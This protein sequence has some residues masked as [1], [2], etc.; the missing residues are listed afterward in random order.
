[1]FNYTACPRAL[2]P[3]LVARSLTIAVASLIELAMVEQGL[4]KNKRCEAWCGE[5]DRG[6]LAPSCK[7]AD[8]SRVRAEESDTIKTMIKNRA[9]EGSETLK[10]KV[11]AVLK[12]SSNKEEVEKYKEKGR[13]LNKPTSCL[14]NFDRVCVPKKSLRIAAVPGSA[15][16]ARRHRAFP[17]WR[18]HM[19]ARPEGL[20]ARTLLDVYRVE[21]RYV[22]SDPDANVRFELGRDSSRGS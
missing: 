15:V 22:G 4:A 14:C 3:V 17:D 16:L 21:S 11:E 2:G 19:S 13:E 8:E 12:L 5:T 1:M 6:L 7:A 18:E 9:T 20:G 10:Q